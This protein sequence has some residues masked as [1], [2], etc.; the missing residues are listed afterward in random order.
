MSAGEHPAASVSDKVRLPLEGVRILDLTAV[1]AGPFGTKLLADIGAEVIRIEAPS[2]PDMI[3]LLGDRSVEQFYN[4]NPYF[5][6]YNRNKLSVG[7]DLKT[8]EGRELFLAMAEKSDVV[9]ENFRPGVLTRLGVSYDD[10][11]GRNP[12]IIV[13][14]IPGYSSTGPEAAIP[15]YGPS[16]E[17]LSGLTHLN[18]YL[19]G[20]P[21]KS[22]ISYGDPVAGLF[23]AA[24]VL[25]ALLQRHSSGRGQWVE[26]SQRNALVSLIGEALVAHQWG[27]EVVRS[28]NRDQVF[29]PQGCY[30]CRPSSGSAASAESWVTLSVTSDQQWQLLAA[31]LDRADLVARGDLATADGRHIAHDELDAAIAA[32]TATRTMDDVLMTFER[33]G[34]P[35]S[36][37]FDVAA[38]RDDEHLEARGF[39]IEVDHPMAGRTRLT[40][41]VWGLGSEHRSVRRAPLFGEHNKQVLQSVLGLSEDEVEGLIARGVVSDRPQV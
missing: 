32:W 30:P 21:Q 35:H 1:W 37:V 3:R 13:V 9:I 38:I 4:Y 24:A 33:I 7:L 26:V 10:L 18:G 19:G 23:G 29:A 27:A 15:A 41:P 11:K 40:K 39:L 22:G 14:S 25:L 36:P 31:A 5:G 6:E 20:P 17:Q 28:G 12:E 34:I 8:P 2:R 16:V